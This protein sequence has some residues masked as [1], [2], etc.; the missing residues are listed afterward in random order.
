M[1][2]CVKNIAQTLVFFFGIWY[3]KTIEKICG[4]D[5]LTGRTVLTKTEAAQINAVTL[6]FVGDTVYSLYVRERL[7]LDVGGKSADLQKTAARIVSAK[8]QSEFL[9][10]LLPLLTEEELDVFRRAKNAKKGT[11]SKSASQLEY[12][13]STGF[14]AVLGYLYLTGNEDRIKALL[15]NSDGAEYQRTESVQAF[16]PVRR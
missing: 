15:S 16:K 6:A 12:N 14:E 13:R 11:K 4:V 2:K 10:K 3:N 8:G 1:C 5:M 9:D 7:T